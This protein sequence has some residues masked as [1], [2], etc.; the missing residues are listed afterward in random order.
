MSRRPWPQLFHLYFLTE[1]RRRLIGLA[2]G[3]RGV[4]LTISRGGAGVKVWQDL[5]SAP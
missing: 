3:R 4:R 1:L 2:S 5:V